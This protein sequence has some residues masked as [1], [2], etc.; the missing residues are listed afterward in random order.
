MEDVAGMIFSGPEFKKMDENMRMLTVD[1]FKAIPRPTVSTAAPL[2]S[3]AAA[4]AARD[5]V[6]RISRL[7]VG[8]L[9]NIVSRLPAKDAARTT[10]LAKRWRRV[11]HS[12]PLVLV[13]AHLLS[14][15]SVVGRG[16][17][18]TQFREMGLDS[19]YAG[20]FRILDAMGTLADNVSHVLA[21]H[22]GPFAFVYLAGNNMLYHPDK[23][24]LW[25]KLLAAKGVKELV[26]VNLASK[27]DDQLPIPAELF[28]CTALTKLY[29]GTWCFPDTSTSHLP[30]TAAFPYL[31]ELGL[32][33]LLI[34]DEDLAFLLD[35]CPVLEKLM[36]ARARW[37]VCLR[38]HSRSLRSVQVCMAIVPEINVV[39][40]TRLERLFLWEAWGWGDR[41]LTN[42]SSKVK[43]GHAPKLRFLGF[44]VPGMHQLEIGNTAIM[45]NTKASPN[46]TVPSVQM[47]GV[48]VKLG[49]HFEARMLP[50]FLRCFPNIETLYVQSENDDFKFWGP[51]TG[52]TSKAINLKFW[53]DAGPIECIQRHIKK[54]VL[55]EFRGRK[56]ELDFLK[57][58]AEHAQVLEEMVIVMTHG[59][60]PSDNLG[61][62]LRI[63]MASAKWANGCCKM[64]VFKSPF[65]QEGTAWCYLRGFDFSIEDPFDVSKCREDKCA[66][67]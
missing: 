9:R 36:I 1:V 57:Y 43:I 23:L 16:R 66:A 42:M 20:L 21:A 49:T 24:E 60:L 6:D 64:M 34:K 50:S 4:A 32:C 18:S 48:Q 30:P 51:K 14:D 45:A 63:F 46:T 8:I 25:L 11:W 10:A 17:G 55:R 38:I 27:F 7:P 67:H 61:A 15:R 37:P 31:R 58:I 39:R 53:K 40:A 19:W 29:I 54:L 3:A 44:L 65:E 41:D 26:F 5:G 33:N 56:S 13:D 12:V 47:L 28:N 2:A 59:H 35:R 62:K 22:P 52:G